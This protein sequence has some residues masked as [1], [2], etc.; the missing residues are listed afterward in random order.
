M[1]G[2]EGNEGDEGNEVLSST[3]HQSRTAIAAV[4]I[5]AVWLVWPARY[6]FT[7][8]YA[9]P[10][11]DSG[12]QT[13]R[14]LLAPD[15]QLRFAPADGPL[16]PKYQTCLLVSE[17]RRFYRHPGVDPLAL[18]GAFLSNLHGNRRR[19]GG[20]TITM[21]VAR[22]AKP[23]A[24][25]Y[26]AKLRECLTALRLS[27]HFSKREVLAMYAAHAPMGGNVV[28]LEAASL[29]YFGKR[30][31]E[32]TW[33]EAALLAVLP[34]APSQIHV[35]RGR[36]QLVRKRNR[37]LH[38][39]HL[40]GVL[41]SLS[42]AAACGEPLPSGVRP[43]PFAAP[44]A[45]ELAARTGPATG[46][47]YTTID[48]RIQAVVTGA[49][50]A[51]ARRLRESGVRNVAALVMQTETGAVLAYAGSQGYDDTLADGRVDGVLARRSY[52]SLL[53]PFLAACAL[54]RGPWTL[55]SR[56][57]DVPTFYGTFAPQN[58]AREYA[59]LV[60][61]EQMLVRSLN[62]PA[63]RLLNAYGVRDFY[64]FLTDVGL[65]GL[66]RTPDGYGLAL[67]LGGAEAHLWELCGMYA[68]LGNLGRRT[69]PHLLTIGQGN[70]R[71][72]TLMASGAAWLVLKA[73]T[74]LE[75]PGIEAYWHNF[76]N[77]VPV[78]WKTGTSYGQKDAWAIG[79]N[80]Q[81]TIGV[82]TGNFDGEGNAALTG[83]GSSA[84]LL[85]DLFNVLS[86]TDRPAW[87]EMP[88]S[89]L[90]SVACCA[91]S[92]YAVGPHCRD[93]IELRV[94]VE[95]GR[96]QRCPF[97]RTFIVDRTTGCSLCSRCWDG[98]DTVWQHRAI[99]PP[100]ARSIL[101]RTGHAADS[102]PRHAAHCP[103]FS[104]SA[105]LSVVYPVNG[106][107]IFVPRDLDGDYE[108]VVYSARH[109]RGDATLFWFRDGS[110][111]GQT[112]GTHELAD[113]PEPGVH[114]LAVQDDEGFIRTVTYETTKSVEKGY[115][116]A[117]AGP[118]HEARPPG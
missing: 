14:V 52:G 17:D 9:R 38:Q 69:V 101:L 81:W 47:I 15:D 63:V 62:V 83:A 118:P 48:A 29:R 88:E 87:P 82:W 77:Q 50:S 43:L 8:G 27:V 76:G 112:T 70:A 10:V 31:Q 80:R 19:R 60:T 34:N 55:Q 117:A 100:Q 28:G 65:G 73:L 40:R 11:V 91:Q 114:S 21:Q 102:I 30:G 36:A 57:Q 13:L 44:H 59:G 37:L 49:V 92:G 116:S 3:S 85:F 78:A 45:A 23:K 106:A 107:R 104:D 113:S 51:Y 90:R 93:T 115:D 95:A 61:V 103:S 97:C 24:R 4:L 5:A 98:R 33:A 71:A 109:Q 35:G 16:P 75:R 1:T 108:K 56:L 39:L 53:K 79:V 105:R 54:Q 12:G 22:L 7:C 84:P 6:P 58:A 41:D 94:P 67:I 111:L 66:F 46:A 18:G 99:V 42:C 64:E 32:L 26:V 72:D 2:N 96:S 89:G 68:T 20:S 86:R 110:Y 25:T 74:G